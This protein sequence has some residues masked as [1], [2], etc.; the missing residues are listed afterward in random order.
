MSSTYEKLWQSYIEDVRKAC[1]TKDFLTAEKTILSA[2]ND[3]EEIGEIDTALVWCT[4]YL[5]AVLQ[6]HGE[7]DR[8]EKL[9][10]GLLELREK[11]FGPCH[12]DVA[13]SLDSI[14]ALNQFRLNQYD[15]EKIVEKNQ[16]TAEEKAEL[17]KTIQLQNIAEFYCDHDNYLAAEQAARQA[18]QIKETIL[19][20]DHPE[21]IPDLYNLG[22]IYFQMDKHS[23]AFSLFVRTLAIEEASLTSNH[24]QINETVRTIATLANEK[25]VFASVEELNFETIA[26]LYPVLKQSA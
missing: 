7:R 11:T 24:P 14:I 16:C 23:E 25:N 6:M 20:P 15:V 26:N 2:F 4:H 10:K 19:G 13:E 1:R 18:L 12:K 22:L 17:D 5:A 9:Y 21:I 8:A 3:A